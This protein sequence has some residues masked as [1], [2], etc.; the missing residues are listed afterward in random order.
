MGKAR[1][2]RFH[3][4]VHDGVSSPDRDGIDLP[5]FETAQAEAVRL[6]G[7]LLRDQAIGDEAIKPLCVEVTDKGGN[8]LL[9]VAV[10]L[11]YRSTPSRTIIG[12]VVAA[13]A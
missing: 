5:D 1:V 9:S 4:N 7:G 8:V 13:M 10:T 2:P 6:T 12:E 11:T 3:F